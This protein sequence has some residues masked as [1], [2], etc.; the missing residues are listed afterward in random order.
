MGSPRRGHVSLGMADLVSSPIIRWCRAPP[1]SCMLALRC[2]ELCGVPGGVATGTPPRHD[3]RPLKPQP[4]SCSCYRFQRGRLEGGHPR[5]SSSNYRTFV[6]GFRSLPF[7]FFP[8]KPEPGES[9]KKTMIQEECQSAADGSAT[10]ETRLRLNQPH[11]LPTR[12]RPWSQGSPATIRR[13]ACSRKS[14]A[15]NLSGDEA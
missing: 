5:Q 13:L 9:D 12:P 2:H 6:Q 11:T 1:Q 7:R 14:L 15:A 8:M 10:C 4:F 3:S